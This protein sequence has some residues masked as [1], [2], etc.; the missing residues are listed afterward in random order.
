MQG[1]CV[2]QGSLR[3]K[4]GTTVQVKEVT[5]FIVFKTIF[6]ISSGGD[7]SEDKSFGRWRS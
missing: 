1:Q 6:Q 5:V 7:N 2:T 4:T 3:M